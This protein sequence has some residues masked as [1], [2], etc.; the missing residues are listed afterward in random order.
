MKSETDKDDNDF[1]DLVP[2]EQSNI[3]K[4]HS[5]TFVEPETGR[6]SLHTLLKFR[7]WESNKEIYLKVMSNLIKKGV[8]VNQMWRQD[9]ENLTCLELVDDGATNDD[10]C[11]FKRNSGLIFDPRTPNY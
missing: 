10:F 3:Y 5:L 2:D 11:D 8:N 4:E 1:F 9:N 6:T 7:E